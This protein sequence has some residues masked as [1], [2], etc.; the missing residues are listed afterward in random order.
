[1]SNEIPLVT[2]YINLRRENIII[3]C[4]GR[5]FHTYSSDRFQLLSVSPQHEENIT[6]LAADSYL[7][8]TS[9][10]NKI[11]AWR[12]GVELKHTYDGHQAA[13]KLLFPFAA[14]LVSID[15]SGIVKVWFVKTES[16]YKEFKL[17]IIATTICHPPTYTNKILI[18][19]VEGK[20]Q[21]WNM[22]T[23]I[24]I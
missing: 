9:C 8:F 24:I 3:T 13:V 1:V 22:N 11:Y 5:A 18:G 20:L 6:C 12:R 17:N 23:G 10:G 14:H 15:E 2:R 16:I 19:S 21:L 7:V 4:V